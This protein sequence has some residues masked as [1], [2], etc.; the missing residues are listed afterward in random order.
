MR[1]TGPTNPVLKSALENLRQISAEEESAIWKRVAKDL[2]R[3]RRIRRSVN[4]STIERECKKG[5]KIVVPGKVL[6]YGNLSKAIEISAWEFSRMAADKI[7]KAGG[8]ALPLEETAKKNPKGKGLRI[9][10]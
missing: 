6:S 2:T 8:K 1:P 4:L 5:D 9:I 10:G 7:E 3:P